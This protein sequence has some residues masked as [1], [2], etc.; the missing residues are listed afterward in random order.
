MKY[1]ERSIIVTSGEM[2]V[3]QIIDMGDCYFFI[4]ISDTDYITDFENISDKRLKLK[5]NFVVSKN[6]ITS[7]DIGVEY[8][9]KDKDVVEYAEIKLRWSVRVKG[10]KGCKKQKKSFSFELADEIPTEKL[11]SFF[12]GAGNV[13]LMSGDEFDDLYF[14]KLSPK[15]KLTRRVLMIVLI[16][17]SALSV[18]FFIIGSAAVSAATT[19]AMFSLCALMPLVIYV[20]NFMFKRYFK[21]D[22][23]HDY[24]DNRNLDTLLW[25][26]VP[27]IINLFVMGG[28][29]YELTFK[30]I[31]L[32][33]AISILITLILVA[34]YWYFSS[35]ATGAVN[36]ILNF[37][38]F[39][40]IIS[41]SSIYILNFTCD[42]SQPSTYEAVIIDKHIVT[43]VKGGDDYRIE[44]QSSNK[45][46]EEFDIS[47]KKYEALEIGDTVTIGEYSGAFGIEYS[48]IEI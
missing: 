10:N 45:S 26:C 8:I 25:L 27:T 19:K 46:S 21:F 32:W 4:W 31:I 42:T 13:N 3:Y 47:Y 48:K 28:M 16:A 20:L 1:G 40:L 43:G 12:D 23:E 5:K 30:A 39:T 14:P 11:R 7:T 24:R 34:V 17:V 38:V 18:L 2:D 37:A 35:K 6:S 9:G 33:T 15:E 44:V 22:K 41:L 29:K 36:K